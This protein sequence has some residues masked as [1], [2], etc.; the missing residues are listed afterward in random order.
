M[1]KLRMNQRQ[2][3]WFAGELSMTLLEKIKVVYPNAL[4]GSNGITLPTPEG[5]VAGAWLSI[6]ISK[7]Y[8][9]E[10]KFELRKNKDKELYIYTRRTP[11]RNGMEIELWAD[12]FTSKKAIEEQALMDLDVMFSIIG[13]DN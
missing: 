2:L 5:A 1:A 8:S 4:V 12:D 10:M 9:F 6:W 13:F 11:E 3:T 7:D